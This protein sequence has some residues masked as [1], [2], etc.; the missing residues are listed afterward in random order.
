VSLRLLAVQALAVTLAGLPVRADSQ[1]RRQ[2]ETR[3][4]RSVRAGA[5]GSVRS[6]VGTV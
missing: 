5:C 6:C 3:E 1:T 4:K 2:S